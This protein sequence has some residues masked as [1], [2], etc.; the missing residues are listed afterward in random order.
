MK[1]QTKNIEWL[2]DKPIAHRGLIELNGYVENS[3]KAFLNCVKKGYAIETDVRYDKDKNLV[4]FHDK[5]LIRLADLHLEIKD[6]SKTQLEKIKLLGKEKIVFFDELLNLVNGKV[7]ILIEIKYPSEK[8]IEKDLLNAL[9]YYDGKYAFQSF[10]PLSLM[11][12][13]KLAPNVLRGQLITLDKDRPYTEKLKWN[14]VNKFTSPDF[15]SVNADGLKFSY[16]LPTLCYTIKSEEDFKKAM[17]FSDNIIAED[18]LEY[19]I[20]DNSSTDL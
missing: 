2:F 9:K 14:F 15:L 12:L 16:D 20:S 1:N 7:P 13:K 5:D 11:R 10:N 18:F 6:L 8:T 17:K 19:G 4:C 3:E